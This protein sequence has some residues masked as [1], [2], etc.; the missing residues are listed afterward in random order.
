MTI[1]GRKN[2]LLRYG[3]E[4]IGQPHA[5]KKL[6]NYLSHHYT[7]ELLQNGWKIYILDTI[8]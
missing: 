7:Y 5:N 6:N 8:P 4:K 3:S 2:N 1:Q